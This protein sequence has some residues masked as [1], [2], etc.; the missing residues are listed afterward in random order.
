MSV[1]TRT[2]TI[3]AAFLQEIKEDNQR[4]RQLLNSLRQKDTRWK[5]SL[6]E[7]AVALGQLRDQLAIHFSLEEAFGYFEDPL[8]IAPRLSEQAE[9]LRLQHGDLYSQASALADLA[10]SRSRDSNATEVWEGFAVF[11]AA[12]QE[13]EARENEL[14][15]RAFTVDLGVGD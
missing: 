13:H 3:N 9:E 2:V 15:M 5:R 7:L 12:L 10:D 4:L 14:I 6:Q 1:V 11:D 8:R